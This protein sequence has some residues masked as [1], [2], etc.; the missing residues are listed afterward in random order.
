MKESFLFAEELL[1][2]D[3]NLVMANFDVEL[4]FTNIPL[5][6]TIYLFVELVCNDKPNIDDFTITDFHELLTI[7]MSESLVLFNSEYYKQ[8][9]SVEMGSP[10]GPTFANIFLKFGSKI[11][12]VNLNLS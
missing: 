3:S 6:E 8:I 5:Q 7:N 12:L 2:Y 9:D 11:V 1:D 4:L 10:L